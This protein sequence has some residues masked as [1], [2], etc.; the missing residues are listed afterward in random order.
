MAGSNCFTQTRCRSRLILAHQSKE[1]AVRRCPVNMQRWKRTRISVLSFSLETGSS[2][3]RRTSCSC[4][5]AK[6]FRRTVLP[7][8]RGG[9]PQLAQ[10]DSGWHSHSAVRGKRPGTPSLPQDRP[11]LPPQAFPDVL[12]WLICGHLTSPPVARSGPDSTVGGKPPLLPQQT[13]HRW[14]L[15]VERRVGSPLVPERR[16]ACAHGIG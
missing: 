10:T 8:G 3:A 9:T 11:D 14:A 7:G 5:R 1:K 13:R 2:R 4:S 6:D 15:T 12:G 16:L